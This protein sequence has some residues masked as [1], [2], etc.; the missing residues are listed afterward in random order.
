MW[1]TNSWSYFFK[2]PRAS[3]IGLLNSG[4]DSRVPAL[5]LATTTGIEARATRLMFLEMQRIDRPHPLYPAACL[6]DRTPVP[7]WVLVLSG[8][9]TVPLNHSWGFSREK[10]VFYFLPSSFY[11][12]YRSTG[13]DEEMQNPLLPRTINLTHAEKRADPTM[14]FIWVGYGERDYMR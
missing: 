7:N 9:F 1:L 10:M 12:P 11:Q 2:P 6:S 8:E 13:A 14:E 3:I 5:G 4:Q